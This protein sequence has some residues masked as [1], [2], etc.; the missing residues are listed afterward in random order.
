MLRKIKAIIQT[1]WIKTFIF[2]LHY[3][4]LKGLKAKCFVAYN[5]KFD[6][7]GGKIVLQ[8][9]TK[10]RIGYFSNYAEEGY[11]KHFKFYNAGLI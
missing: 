9:N 3:F 5:V 8:D 6:K 4:G 2:N 10:L 7:L 11:H 1:N